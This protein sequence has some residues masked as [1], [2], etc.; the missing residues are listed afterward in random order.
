MQEAFSHETAVKYNLTGKGGLGKKGFQHL[1]L[2]RII[3]GELF[4]RF[5]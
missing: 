3:F 4:L 1:R 2:Y 5:S